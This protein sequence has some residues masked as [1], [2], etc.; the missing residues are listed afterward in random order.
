MQIK[1]HIARNRYL[2]RVNTLHYVDSAQ[3]VNEHIIRLALC[4]YTQATEKE[5]M[6]LIKKA[7]CLKVRKVNEK[8]EHSKTKTK[9]EK[10]VLA[11]TLYCLQRHKFLV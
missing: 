4:Q 9:N 2:M 10:Y 7:P 11:A 8:M 1:K 6:H 5:N 3:H